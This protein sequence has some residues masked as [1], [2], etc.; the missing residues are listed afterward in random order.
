MKSKIQLSRLLAIL[1]DGAFHS[2]ESLGD[3]FGV[4]RAAIWKALQILKEQGFELNHLRGRGYQLCEPVEL[5]SLEKLQALLSPSSQR[6]YQIALFDCIGSTNQYFT[7][8]KQAQHGDVCI[9]EQQLAGR[10]RLGRAWVSPFARNIYCSSY[11]TFEKCM[12]EC[13]GLS[14][15]VGVACIRALQRAEIEGVELKWPNDLFYQGQKLGGILIEMSGDIQGPCQAVIGI[16]M[17]VAMPKSAYPD[18]A[19]WTDL[20]SIS[21]QAPSRNRLLAYLLDALKTEL[22]L[23][24]TAGMTSALASWREWDYLLDKPVQV[25]THQQGA[26][27]TGIAR[28][29]DERGALLVEHDGLVHT[30]H[31]A[32]V[33][34]R[35]DFKD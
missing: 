3:V 19:T 10:G 6:A 7:G 33:S 28:G 25:L 27:L 18:S 8:N 35:P 4:S 23:F 24:T 17:N 21:G 15:L 5:L 14:L 13:M 1:S 32:D 12:G 2:G 29:I 16:G 22:D 20:S 31:S 30:Y 11:W 26:S 34:I 9:A